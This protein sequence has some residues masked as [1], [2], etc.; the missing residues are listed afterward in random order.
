MLGVRGVK[1]S[2]HDRLQRESK[3]QAG[4]SPEQ[5]VQV[6]QGQKLPRQQGMLDAFVSL[7]K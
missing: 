6:L 3:R 1:T 5:L 4:H 7:A 2:S